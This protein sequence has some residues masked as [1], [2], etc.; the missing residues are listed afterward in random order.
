VGTVISEDE[1]ELIYLQDGEPAEVYV[2]TLRRM[3]E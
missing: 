1:I 3:A 2:Q